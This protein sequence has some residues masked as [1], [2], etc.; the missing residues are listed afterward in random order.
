M[1]ELAVRGLATEKASNSASL[2]NKLIE[3]CLRKPALLEHLV[4][5]FKEHGC[6]DKLALLEKATLRNRNLT[7]QSLGTSR[8]AR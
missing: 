3:T 5:C 4:S 1:I 7:A 8:Y 2:A 6:V